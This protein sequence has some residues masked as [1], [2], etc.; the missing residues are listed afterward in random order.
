M[1]TKQQ[2]RILC[3]EYFAT[4]EKDRPVINMFMDLQ[5]LINT[6]IEEDKARMMYEMSAVLTDYTEAK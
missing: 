2:V 3:S 5:T 6:A 1:V 4:V